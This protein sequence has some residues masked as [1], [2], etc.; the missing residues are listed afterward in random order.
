MAVPRL[1]IANIDDET[2]ARIQ[3][4]EKALEIVI[5]ALEPHFPLANLSAD[6]VE[7]IKALEEELGVYLLAY[8]K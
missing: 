1:K 5:L 3:K 2:L 7:K 4:M 8:E 6:Q